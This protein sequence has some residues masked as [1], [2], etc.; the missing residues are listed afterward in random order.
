MISSNKLSFTLTLVFLCVCASSFSKEINCYKLVKSSDSNVQ[1]GAYQFISFVGD[2]CYESN[3][4][5]ISMKYGTLTINKYQSSSNRKVYSGNCFCGKAKF[6]FNSDRS[7]LKIEASNGKTYSFEETAAPS[8]VSTCQ[9]KRKTGG[10]GVNH[11][12]NYASGISPNQSPNGTPPVNR[13]ANSGI[14][15]G[16]SVVGSSNSQ[17]VEPKK[18]K[19]H[20]C[21]Q[22]GMITRNDNAPASFGISQPKKQCSTCGEWFD[23]T[24]RNHYHIKCS[25]CNGTGF[26]Q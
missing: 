7:E 22:T 11:A 13:N 16:N 5:G 1:I 6:I 20:Y 10:Q 14:G 24:V 25:H 18:L 4:E 3:D 21:N 15:S 9:L 23:P 8:N 26:L 17:R 12:P 19:C 2:I